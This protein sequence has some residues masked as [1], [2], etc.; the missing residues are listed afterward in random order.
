MNRCLARIALSIL[1]GVLVAGC[2]VPEVNDGQPSEGGSPPSSFTSFTTADGLVNERVHAVGIDSTGGKWFGTEGGVSYLDDGGT[3]ANKADDTWISY[4]TVDGLAHNVVLGIGVD[5]SAGK[6][7]ETYGG[8]V[9]YLDDNGTPTAK[10]DDGWTTFTESDGLGNMFVNV[11][12]FDTSGGKWFGQVGD[13]ASYLDDNGTPANQT[14]DIWTNLTVLDGLAN[15]LVYGVAIDASGGKWFGTLDGV[16]YLDDS[17]TPSSKADDSWTK[18]T[19]AD[20]L[21]SNIVAALAVDASGGKWFGT[22]S[23]VSYLDDGGTPANKADDTWITF[24]TADGLIYDTVKAVVIDGSGRK[25]FGTG[26]GLGC[27]D[28]GGTPT[29]KADD[30]WTEFHTADGLVYGEVFAVAVDG[31][32]GKWIGTAM[33]VS[34]CVP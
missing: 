8:G 3:P 17:G 29:S 28:D 23:G 4:T 30:I 31:S 13:G 9:S 21:A 2:P 26:G 16:S 15:Q 20:G 18:F 22:N 1:S 14:D 34:Y 6:W 19:T 24:T 5:G 25:W 32:G 12:A 27:L 7:F 10:G 11:V 33:G